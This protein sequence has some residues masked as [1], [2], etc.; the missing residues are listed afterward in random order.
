MLITI[1]ISNDNMYTSSII[2]CYIA[3]SLIG[4]LMLDCH[5]YL[6]RNLAFLFE[7]LVAVQLLNCMQIRQIMKNNSSCLNHGRFVEIIYTKALH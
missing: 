2:V 1:Y 5:I 7:L 6:R 3:N 4:K